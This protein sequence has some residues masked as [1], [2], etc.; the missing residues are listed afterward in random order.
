MD[1]PHNTPSVI[2][3]LNLPKERIERI[4]IEA[5]MRSL[6]I[7]VTTKGIFLRMKVVFENFLESSQW[8]FHSVLLLN[9]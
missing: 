8:N 5:V 4:L 1:H 2:D 9:V 6:L 3:N 7:K